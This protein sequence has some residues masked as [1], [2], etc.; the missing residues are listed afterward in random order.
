M[1]GRAPRAAQPPVLF[2]QT[3]FGVSSFFSDS[4]WGTRPVFFTDS[5]CTPGQD[6]EVWTAEVDAFPCRFFTVQ[7]GFV[8]P[9]ACAWPGPGQKESGKNWAP[10]WA[11]A[12]PSSSPAAIAVS[13]SVKRSVF[14]KSK[15]TYILFYY[16]VRSKIKFL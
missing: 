1:A 15:C 10:P 6:G 8:G 9:A 14:V 16:T 11:C 12:D 4:F 5:F 3:P 7:Q 2:L 13:R